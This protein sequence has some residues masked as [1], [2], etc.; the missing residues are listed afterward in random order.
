MAKSN[1]LKYLLDNPWKYVVAKPGMVMS[2][3]LNDETEL[4]IEK[5]GFESNS[6]AV[7]QLEC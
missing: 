6:F 7:S 5:I 3:G 2:I 1:R 4:R